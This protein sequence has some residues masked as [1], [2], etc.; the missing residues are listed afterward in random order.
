MQK[1]VGGAALLVTIALFLIAV[2]RDVSSNTLG[3]A[4]WISGAVCGVGGGTLIV[5]GFRADRR[6]REAWRG[7]DRFCDEGVAPHAETGN[8]TGEEARKHYTA[9]VDSWEERTP[10]LLEKNVPDS[11]GDF[12]IPSPLAPTTT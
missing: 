12:K 3:L 1:T 6:Q 5:Q 4:L 2:G 9:Q 11:A 8:E 7:L 10:A